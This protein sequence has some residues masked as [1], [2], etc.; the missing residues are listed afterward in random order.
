MADYPTLKHVPMEVREHIR[1]RGNLDRRH[2]YAATYA[3]EAGGILVLTDVVMESGERVEDITLV[4]R[5]S[6]RKTLMISPAYH[7]TLTEQEEKP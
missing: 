3:I 1:Y 6:H 2:F 5:W 4:E 7:W